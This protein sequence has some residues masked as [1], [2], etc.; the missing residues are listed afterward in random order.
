[1]SRLN[2]LCYFWIFVFC[3]VL[4]LPLDRLWAV[5][6]LRAETVGRE[7]SLSVEGEKAQDDG[8]KIQVKN[9]YVEDETTNTVLASRLGLWL[10]L[11]ETGDA[12]RSSLQGVGLSYWWLGSP[13]VG[14]W[15]GLGLRSSQW[16]GSGQV[17]DQAEMFISLR[18]ILGHWGEWNLSGAGGIAYVYSR[19]YV[20]GSGLP[21]RAVDSSS[22]MWGGLQFGRS[23]GSL[24]LLSL[25]LRWLESGTGLVGFGLEWF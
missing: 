9:P 1:M 21:L 22:P 8:L 6:S 7:I 20:R 5:E 12:N 13:W 17:R 18:V 2:V 16:L 23:V 10:H 24:G 25:Q 3:A 11:Q 4:F 14:V 15:S 19:D